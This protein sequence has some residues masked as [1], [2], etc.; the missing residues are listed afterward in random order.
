MVK[1]KELL[2]PT[3][4]YV[5]CRIFGY[6]GNEDITK[7]LLE[8]ITNEK[9]NSII[10]ENQIRTAKSF[11]NDKVGILDIRAENNEYIF[12]IE[13]QVAR[14]EDMP[15]RM[16]WYWA[17]LYSSDVKHAEKYSEARKVIS[18]LIADF[19]LDVLKDIKRYHSSWHIR[20]DELST[21]ILTKKFEMHIIELKKLEVNIKQQGN[22][23][24]EQWL[25]FIRNPERGKESCMYEE[26]EKARKVLEDISQDEEER[27]LAEQREVWKIDQNSQ[28][29]SATKKG[30][31]EGIKEG[32][33]EG[34]SKNKKETAKRMLEKN[35]DIDTIVEITQLSKEDIEKL[36]D[37]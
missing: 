30:R 14:Y 22:K 13:M 18:I 23:K 21:I 35:Y 34:I 25:R 15:D 31:E 11:N 12:N 29:Y 32:R 8:S 27:K 24:L 33:E 17:K 19:N 9:Y 20:E 7:D 36:K 3:N 10:I 16:L 1:K 5:F 4:D 28:L 2:K 37:E 26:I 6:K